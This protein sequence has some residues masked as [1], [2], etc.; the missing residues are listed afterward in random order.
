MFYWPHFVKHQVGLELPS[1]A[2]Q[3]WIWPDQHSCFSCFLIN[4]FVQPAQIY[5]ILTVS[6]TLRLAL[7]YQDEC[8]GLQGLPLWRVDVTC[9][10]NEHY[11][12]VAVAPGRAHSVDEE[13]VKKCMGELRDFL[14]E[15]HLSSHSVIAT[16]PSD[17][18]LRKQNAQGSMGRESPWGWSSSAV[19]SNEWG[20]WK[21][22]QGLICSTSTHLQG[23]LWGQSFLRKGSLH[24]TKSQ[25]ITS[26][27]LVFRLQ[28]AV[29]WRHPLP[30]A[31]PQHLC[32]PAAKNWL[33]M[34]IFAFHV[35]LWGWC[36]AFD[37]PEHKAYPLPS[38]HA[39]LWSVPCG[40]Q[41]SHSSTCVWEES[42][43][44]R[45]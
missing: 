32:V 12:T 29:Y 1:V 25:K 16:S 36:H 22:E 28:M 31:F 44:A 30:S 27:W 42:I 10:R 5:L 4:S 8:S 17:S 38:Q 40:S 21:D 6:H 11:P 2:F 19:W 45:H 35:S 3:S 39:L 43:M 24:P 23:I 41:T 18:R 20:G 33:E 13:G 37:G 9:Q 14:K 15:G 26:P 7:G 34:G